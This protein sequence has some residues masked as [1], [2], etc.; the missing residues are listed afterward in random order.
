MRKKIKSDIKVQQVLQQQQQ[1]QQRYHS[2]I[3][4]YYHDI[5]ICTNSKYANYPNKKQHKSCKSARHLVLCEYVIKCRD[6]FHFHHLSSNLQGLQR[7]RGR[8]QT[9]WKK[10]L[11]KSRDPIREAGILVGL[12]PEPSKE[13]RDVE[14]KLLKS[15]GSKTQK[16]TETLPELY[17][18]LCCLFFVVG[19][20]GS[21][22][23]LVRISSTPTHPTVS[24][25]SPGKGGHATGRIM[26]TAISIQSRHGIRLTMA[27]AE[28]TTPSRV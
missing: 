26:A 25:E 20:R 23:V 2:N 17:L 24:T 15:W 22:W 11:W 6:A 3:Y 21:L 27:T 5:L 19:L 1:Q 28:E 4:I 7:A 14:E 18:Y 9:H 12:V 10:L 16:K 13:S 8:G